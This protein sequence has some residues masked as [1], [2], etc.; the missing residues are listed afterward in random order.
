MRVLLVED[1]HLAAQR[2]EGMLK[3]LNTNIEVVK[4]CDSIKQTIKWLS[5]HEKP[6]LSFFDIQLGDGLSFEIFS[7]LEID[8]PVVF[9]TAYDQYAVKA[10]E[11]NGL[12]YLLKP[13]E[14]SHLKRA[15]DK[16]T[17]GQ[18]Q[19]DV[20]LKMALINAA[21]QLKKGD[22]KTRYLIKVGEHLKMVETSDIAFAYSMDKANYIRTIDGHNY[23]IDHSMEQMVLQLDPENF[24][25]ISRK[26]LVN[27]SAINDMISYGT[28]RLKLK[29][30]GMDTDDEI[31]VSRDKVKAFKDWLER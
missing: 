29:V 26:H 28:S 9:T 2:L 27:I 18:S 3:K 6:D 15:L 7:Q 24:F 25:R 5:E 31:V 21:R 11:V 16:F 20:T 19:L 10:F 30:K 23:N 17:K 4:V 22:Y 14:E 8:F 1:E 13:I 12:D